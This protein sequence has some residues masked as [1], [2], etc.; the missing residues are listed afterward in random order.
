ML[1]KEDTLILI[2]FGLLMMIGGYN[3][4]SMMVMQ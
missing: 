3:I 1:T 2:G 4:D